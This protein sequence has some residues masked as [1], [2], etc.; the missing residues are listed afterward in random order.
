MYKCADDRWVTV[1]AS[2]PRTWARLCEG[3]ALPNMADHKMGVNEVDAK[4]TVAAAFARKPAAEW[5]REPGLAG[6]VGPVNDP[7]DLVHDPQL[8]GRDS[9][10]TLTNTTTSVL[11]NPLRFD[12]ASGDA[13]TLARSAPP[14]LGE[15]TDQ[16]LAEA[17]FSEEEIAGLRTAGVV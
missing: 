9:L 12:G 8:S 3:L 14:A 11:A 1:A 7:A 16:A 17:G 5:L 13:A 4:A 15:H 6:G 2:E 10:V